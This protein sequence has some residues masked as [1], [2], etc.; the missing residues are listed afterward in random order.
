[1]QGKLT[2]PKIDFVLYHLNHHLNIN[3]EIRKR[4]KFGYR[5]Q[6]SVSGLVYFPLSE[7]SLDDIKYIDKVPILFPLSDKNV[8]FEVRN[9][10]DLVFFDDLMKSAFYLLSGYQEVAS[11]SSDKHGRFSY[12]GSIQK[13]LDIAM[14][15]LVNVYF[16][17]IVKGFKQFC[18]QNRIPFEERQRWGGNSY[19]VSLTHDVDRIDKW[20]WPEIKLRVKKLAGII[21]NENS[22]RKR[23]QDLWIP[24]VKIIQKENP[25]WNFNWLKTLESKLNIQSAWFF[26]PKGI[27]HIDAYY[28]FTEPRIRKLVADLLSEG[29]EIG[30]HATYNSFN[31]IKI[32]KD[33]YETIKKLLDSTP[34]G[35]RQ[36]WLR[37]CFPETLRIQENTG[38]EYDTSWGFH[39]HIGWRN[40]YCLPFRPYDLE[41]DQMMNIWEIPLS[42]MDRSL[43][44]YQ[45][46]D[47]FE[48]AI[49]LTDNLIQSTI[50]F[51][52]LLVILW[53]N[54]Y[55]SF[56]DNQDLR[57]IYK[58]ILMKIKK[59]NGMFILPREVVQY[60][61][62][63]DSNV[64]NSR[65]D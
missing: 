6:Y 42:F 19:A 60:F 41:Y 43:F 16:E 25:Y 40:S 12:H 37:F 28:T 57:I 46:P 54:S 7:Q 4:L 2:K 14:T 30:L 21:P 23:I 11:Y 9:N 22:F 15:P 61:N 27:K 44:D 5:K 45:T 24:L 49:E 13:K 47:R 51:R 58:N 1:M 52:G 31:D 17:I 8:F 53:H 26:L 63:F 29:D 18:K 55:F 36:H 10:G 20:N 38:F 50:R 65:W 33:N 62:A 32:M 34:S 56:S 39:D 59:T 48:N 64:D 35:V 3:S